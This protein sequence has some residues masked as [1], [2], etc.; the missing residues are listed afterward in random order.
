MKDILLPH[1]TKAKN[2]VPSARKKG[3]VA[4][5]LYSELVVGLEKLRGDTGVICAA[6]SNEYS[7][8]WIRDQLYSTFAYYYTGDHKKFRE[9]VWVV[10]DIL[11]KHTEKIEYTICY[12]PVYGHEYIHAKFHPHTYDEITKDWG[13]HQLD[14]I[15]LFLFMVGF[16]TENKVKI[17]RD[18]KDEELIQLLVLYLSA[19]RYWET[20]DNGMWEEMMDLHTSSIGACVAGLT[21]IKELGIA[22]VP[23]SLI[24]HG[25]EMLYK[26][27]PNE[28]PGR[29]E[30]LAQLSLIW[31]YNLLPAHVEDVILK[32]ITKRLVQKKGVNRYWEDNYY[33]SQN[34]V[35]AEWTMGF[36]WLAIAYAQ[37]GDLKKAHEWFERGLATRTK[38]GDLPELYYNDKPNGNTP[39]AWSHS[40]ALIAAKHIDS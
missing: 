10:F 17:I 2:I 15:G 26:I 22:V 1:I 38:D 35:S 39:L 33:R 21:K 8:C 32:R 25:G 24:A 30:D 3:L 29:T 36:F 12:P 34:G 11:H 6:P 7:S 19:V 5:K 16:S 27:L 9:G 40:L 13:H 31:P 14:A 23:Q 18:K 20:P 37:K 28:S 4:P